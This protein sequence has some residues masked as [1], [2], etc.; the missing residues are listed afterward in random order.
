MW[1]GH[2]YLNPVSSYWC[3]HHRTAIPRRLDIGKAARLQL[4]DA[5]L[6]SYRLLAEVRPLPQI[7]ASVG[8]HP[9][10]MRRDRN[11]GQ[12]FLRYKNQQYLKLKSC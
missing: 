12:L 3:M 2:F 4:S 9:D 7:I 11:C 8:K 5:K 10:S 1:L 6:W